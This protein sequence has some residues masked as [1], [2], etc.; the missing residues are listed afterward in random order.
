MPAFGC[1]F[2]E[3]C[4]REQ[5]ESPAGAYRLID[6]AV[7]PMVD[8]CFICFWAPALVALPA[9]YTRDGIDATAD[10]VREWEKFAVLEE[11]SA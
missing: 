6:Q 4:A 9:R 8:D 2:R 7:S 10:G 11:S 3:S 1:W 5:E